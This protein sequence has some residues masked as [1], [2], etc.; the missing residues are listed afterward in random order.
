MKLKCFCFHKSGS[1]FFYRLFRE[2]A[3]INNIDYYSINKTSN[4]IDERVL[5][6][7]MWNDEVEK[8]ILCPIR[9]APRDY[10]KDLKY[11]IHFRNPLDIMISAYY[12]F[13]YTHGVPDPNSN[14]EKYD[15]FMKRRKI[16]QSQTIDEYCLSQENIDEINNKYND[17]FIWINKYKNNENVLIS[18]YDKMYYDFP[19]WFRDIIKFLSVGYY[20]ELLNKFKKEFSNSSEEVIKSD[21]NTVNKHHRSGLSKQYLVELKKETI[22]TVISKFTDTIKQNIN[23]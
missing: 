3:Y 14:K 20:D 5:P 15:F 19:N 18:E 9:G 22:D 6:E 21:V 17:M 8:Y 4:D 11:I 1:T 7:C 16:I 23:F 10:R 13:G 2:I 12:S